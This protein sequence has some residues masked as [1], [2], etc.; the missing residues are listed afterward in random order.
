MAAVS[1][2]M[3]YGG[4]T[5]ATAAPN[6]VA[7]GTMCSWRCVEG[8]QGVEWNVAGRGLETGGV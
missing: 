2:L 3:L 7:R 8:G 4:N 5:R 1:D 6:K